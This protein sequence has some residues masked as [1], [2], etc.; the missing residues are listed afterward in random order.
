[1]YRPAGDL[2]FLKNFL[3]DYRF[4][5]VTDIKLIFFPEVFQPPFWN[6]IPEE[7]IENA[8][9]KSYQ[10]LCTDQQEIVDEFL[11]KVE[12][13][14]KTVNVFPKSRSPLYFSFLIIPMT[15]DCTHF[16]LPYFVLY[17]KFSSSFPMTVQP[18]PSIYRLKI[19]LTISASFSYWR[20]GTQ[21]ATCIKRGRKGTSSA[22]NMRLAAW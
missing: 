16:E 4:V 1:M 13:I 22:G 15:V 6:R 19:Y 12:G 2:C 14:L 7:V 18:A 11:Q 21:T 5:M 10:L 9:V 17:P 8:F 20:S 3:T